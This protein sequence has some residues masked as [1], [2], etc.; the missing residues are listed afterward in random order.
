MKKNP[1]VLGIASCSVTVSFWIL[2]LLTRLLVGSANIPM[3]I[4]FWVGLP[5]S[6]ALT[7]KAS[8][9]HSDLSKSKDGALS[10]SDKI[11]K[12]VIR[13]SIWLLIIPAALCLLLPFLA[14]GVAYW[15]ANPSTS[16]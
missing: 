13:I 6:I 10:R 15:L 8:T 5:L 3:T 12:T 2:I 14:V 16:L 1:L 4:G 11:A 7:V 9:L